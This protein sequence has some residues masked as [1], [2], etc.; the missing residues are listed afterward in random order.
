MDLARQSQGSSTARMVV[1]VEPE[2]YL[3]VAL[4]LEKPKSPITPEAPSR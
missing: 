3:S 1:M 2:V 4:K